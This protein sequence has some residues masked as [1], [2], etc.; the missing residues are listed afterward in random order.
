[1][2][3]ILK[4]ITTTANN[5]QNHR[6]GEFVLLTLLCF[7]SKYKVNYSIVDQNMILVYSLK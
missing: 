2:R 4:T 3:K 5:N 6:Q 1:M 7:L